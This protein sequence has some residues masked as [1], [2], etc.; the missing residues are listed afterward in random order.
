[1]N[2]PTDELTDLERRVVVE[3]TRELPE[4]LAAAYLDT[5][6]EKRYVTKERPGYYKV[7]HQRDGLL[8]DGRIAVLRGE[9]QRKHR[10]ARIVAVA[11]DP[12]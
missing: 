5:L 12:S 1:M 2:H 3:V 11:Q 7:A 6:V 10:G 4:Q 8:P 9:Q